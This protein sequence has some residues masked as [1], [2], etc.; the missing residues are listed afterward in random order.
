MKS[1]K[2][3]QIRKDDKGSFGNRGQKPG[4]GQTAKGKVGSQ[5]GSK[6]AKETLAHKDPVQAKLRK[7]SKGMLG[8]QVAEGQAAM[9]AQL[10]G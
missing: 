5:K 4:T 9:R 8:K 2:P 1:Y 6:Y 7:I 3:A 10:N